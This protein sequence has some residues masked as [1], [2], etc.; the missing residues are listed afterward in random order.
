MSPSLWIASC[1]WP[2]LTGNGLFA[3]LSGSKAAAKRKS[4]SASKRTKK[5]K[6]ADTKAGHTNINDW[7]SDD[8]SSAEHATKQD[9][10]HATSDSDEVNADAAALGRR[11]EAASA[12]KQKK[13]QA[14]QQSAGRK[15]KKKSSG[16]TRRHG[17]RKSSGGAKN[18]AHAKHAR[19]GDWTSDDSSDAQPERII[20]NLEPMSDSDADNHEGNRLDTGSAKAQGMLASPLGKQ[21]KKQFSEE[22]SLAQPDSS[23][24]PA[25]HVS[26]RASDAEEEEDWGQQAAM[27]DDEV[28]PAKQAKRKGRLRKARASPGRPAAAGREVDDVMVDLEDDIP[29]VEMEV[30]HHGREAA[31]K[32]SETDLLQDNLVAEDAG[33]KTKRSGRSVRVGGQDSAK[34]AAR[35]AG[36]LQDK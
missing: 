1:G 27:S 21:C 6:R 33:Q 11:H 14:E 36:K 29:E 23:S 19:A 34:E 8:S 4:S 24:S 13:Q 20:D 31:E 32:L 22:K 2:L 28:Q 12:G 35:H 30:E 26:R 16:G 25:K 10:P 17:K 18:R 7:S 5:Q 3:G 9:E 15:S